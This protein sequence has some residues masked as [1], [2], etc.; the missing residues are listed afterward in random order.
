MHPELMAP[1]LKRDL[2]P[3][4][5]DVLLPQL[6]EAFDR[7][8]IGGPPE[9]GKTKLVERCGR[10]GRPII[11]TDTWKDEPWGDQPAFI[12]DACEAHERLLL[13]GVKVPWAL[14]AGLG[15]SALLWL[16]EVRGTQTKHQVGLGNAA[17]SV[18]K[19]IRDELAKQIP[20]FIVR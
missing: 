6:L 13:E 10:D 3:D 18:F 20:I 12:V 9:T 5:R 7:V 2:R 14:R 8:A 15:I 16:T 11:E 1:G 19:D 4:A 17:I